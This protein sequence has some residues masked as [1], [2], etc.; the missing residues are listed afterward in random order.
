M[1]G[2][3]GKLPIGQI[4]FE[5]ADAIRAGAEPDG[6]LFILFQR[7]L[8]GVNLS[9]DQVAYAFGRRRRSGSRIGG[10]RKQGFLR[11]LFSEI[12]KRHFR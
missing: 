5:H 6:E 10:G 11:E 1:A 3:Y 12:G 9:Q 8:H 7:L 2:E 4:N